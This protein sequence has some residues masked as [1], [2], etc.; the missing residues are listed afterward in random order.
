M[1][2]TNA[3]AQNLIEF[4]KE[5]NVRPSV[6]AGIRRVIIN[7]LEFQLHKEAATVDQVLGKALGYPYYCSDQKN[8]PGSTVA[9]GVCT[10]EH[11]PE[12]LA[13]E[14]AAH[15]IRMAAAINQ[16]LSGTQALEPYVY[17]TLSKGLGT[18]AGPS[19]PPK[20]T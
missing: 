19:V 11:V 7:D 4:S 10:G 13:D 3:A 5:F 6:I 16:V 1:Q 15:L 12:S 20:E 14:A 8:F 2:L 17:S 18:Y 9:D